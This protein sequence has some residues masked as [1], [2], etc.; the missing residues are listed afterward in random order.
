MNQPGFAIK[1]EEAVG[2]LEAL[3][4]AL[5]GSDPQD[6]AKL[7]GLLARRHHAVTQVAAHL[8]D[9]ARLPE[10]QVQRLSQVWQGGQQMEERLKLVAAGLR[11][12]LQ[13]LYRA[14]W[15]TRAFSA[16]IGQAG[17]RFDV[18]A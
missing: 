17:Q 2:E 5:A 8:D 15:H 18:E 16:D 11:G 6:L 3:T 14:A 7:G 4:A 1:L 9:A 10:A 12:Q 13:E